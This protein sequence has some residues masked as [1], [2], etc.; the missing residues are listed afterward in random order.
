MRMNY[1]IDITADIPLLF[2]QNY[3]ITNID[4]KNIFANWGPREHWQNGFETGYID[5]ARWPIT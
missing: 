3:D 5:E 1:I 2:A 4:I